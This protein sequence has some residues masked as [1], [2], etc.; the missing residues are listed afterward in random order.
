MARRD[1]KRRN[2]R[3][4]AGVLALIV[5]LAGLGALLRAFDEGSPTPVDPKPSPLATNGD[6][7][8]V[9]RRERSDMASLYLLDP[10]EG[11][12]RRLLDLKPDCR[13][14]EK[15][16][17]DLW[18]TSVDWS[19]DGTRIAFALY[20]GQIGGVGDRAGI[21]VME[22]ASENPPA[23]SVL[24]DVRGSGRCRMV[25]RWVPDRL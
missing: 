2:K 14:R 8:F 22:V 10:T 7:T 25:P 24:R 16:W 9:G 23:D 5:A 13:R 20:D 4:T 3:F 19:P 11:P 6:I 12:P 17:C 21:Y 18:I 15:R 1:R